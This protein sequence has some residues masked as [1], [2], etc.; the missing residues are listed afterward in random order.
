MTPTRKTKT[1]IK[2]FKIAGITALIVVGIRM[3]LIASFVIPSISMQP[4]ILPGDHILVNK[5]IPGPR[6]D[7]PFSSSS[8]YH[9]GSIRFAGLRNIK[10]NDILVFNI[11]Y[12]GKQKIEKNLNIYYVKRCIGEPGDTLSIKEGV[13]YIYNAD[14]VFK[15][16]ESWKAM[17]ESIGLR[18]YSSDMFKRLGWTLNQFGPLYIPRKGDVVKLNEQNIDYYKTL[19]EYETS[20]PVV[21]KGSSFFQGDKE[22]KEYRFDQ[23]YYFVGGDFAIDSEDSRFWGLLPADHII[24]VASVIWKSVDP[25]SKEYRF[26]RFLKGLR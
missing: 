24:G 25:A 20:H 5:L 22:L 17:L 9:S 14:T 8:E 10:R 7:W 3:L 18:D 19:I 26:N 21:Q 4:T 16:K 2:L 15:A 11:P 1:I 6:I 23:H 13:Y 12:S